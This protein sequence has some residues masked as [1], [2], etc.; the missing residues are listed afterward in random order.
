[1]VS[2]IHWIVCATVLLAVTAGCTQRNWYEGVKQSHVHRCNEVPESEREDCL[3]YHDDNYYDYQ[4][5]RDEI[6]E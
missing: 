2:R 1:M 4:R 5:K 3:S 6:I